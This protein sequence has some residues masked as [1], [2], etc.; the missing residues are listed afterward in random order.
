MLQAIP[1]SVDLWIHYLNHV[2]QAE[3]SKDNTDFIRQQYEKAVEVYLTRL[4]SSAFCY[5]EVYRDRDIRHK[6]SRIIGVEFLM[7]KYDFINIVEKIIKI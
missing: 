5:C 6:I 1:L 4:Y 3:E 7:T 2:K